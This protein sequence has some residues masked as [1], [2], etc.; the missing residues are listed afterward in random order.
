MS[1]LKLWCRLLTTAFLLTVVGLPLEVALLA[2]VAH[3][4]FAFWIPVVPGVVLAMTLP[5][6]LRFDAPAPDHAG[7]PARRLAGS[8]RRSQERTRTR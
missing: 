4:V 1:L 2:V 6:H 5:R 3:R 8:P 7:T